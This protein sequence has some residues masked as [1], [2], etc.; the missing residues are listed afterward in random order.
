[1]F[2]Q[3][4]APQWPPPPPP[5]EDW[6]PF[7]ATVAATLAALVG[8]TIAVLH[9]HHTACAGFIAVAVVG[10]VALLLWPRD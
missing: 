10:A 4:P 7:N 3:R 5:G 2:A 6:N 9:D 1:M 8:A